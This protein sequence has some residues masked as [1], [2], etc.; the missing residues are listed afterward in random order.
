MFNGNLL[1]VP[2]DGLYSERIYTNW[3]IDVLLLFNMLTYLISLLIWHICQFAIR[4]LS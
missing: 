3:S 2:D 1:T 4:D